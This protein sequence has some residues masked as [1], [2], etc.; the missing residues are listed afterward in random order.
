MELDV[1]LKE[2]LA[3]KLWL[4]GFLP[5]FDA[6]CYTPYG[7]EE[8]RHEMTDIDVLGFRMDDFYRAQRV[9]VD[10][11]TGKTSA[12]NRALWLKGL[13]EERSVSTGFVISQK[14]IA[15]DHRQATLNWGVTLLEEREIDD[16]FRQTCGVDT[17]S[18]KCLEL[19]HWLRFRRDVPN[20]N[21]I[22]DLL[23][24]IN[25][26][27]WGDPATR[28]LRYVLME[29]RA[30]RDTLTPTQRLHLALVADCVCLFATSFLQIVSSII[31]VNLVV[32]N[33]S[34][35]DEL[36]KVHIYGGRELYDYMN[37]V[38]K[39]VLDLKRAETPALFSTE[40]PDALS[41][42]EWPAFLS[43]VRAGLEFPREISHT[44]RL[45]RLIAIDRLL[46]G[47]DVDFRKV[48]PQCSLRSLQMAADIVGYFCTA[49][50]LHPGFAE[51]IRNECDR[52]ML[53]MNN[54]S[55]EASP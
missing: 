26:F 40:T 46:V 28:S 16:F 44:P 20:A 36:L 19:E 50:G 12:I 27:F 23:D 3:R 24:Y 22:K 30:V 48:L 54:R 38:R 11:K 25:Y 1:T 37:R 52:F 34:R 17:V 55:D 9:A 2:S 45:L 29:T 15:L 53:S 18:L 7:I 42:P 8:N 43:L 32:D 31:S 13:M 4:L 35:L 14:P 51:A 39:T 47:N 33:E 6:K 21:R 41:L 49:T 10:C 5:Q